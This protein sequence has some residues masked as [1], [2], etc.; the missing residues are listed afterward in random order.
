VNDGLV[1][2]KLP[3]QA[4]IMRSVAERELA[5]SLLRGYNEAI[6]RWPELGSVKDASTSVDSLPSYRAADS[7][8]KD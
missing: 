1:R 6:R 4:G 8:E 7:V 3:F 5:A 2:K